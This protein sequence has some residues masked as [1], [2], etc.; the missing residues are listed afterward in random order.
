MK[1]SDTQQEYYHFTFEL[2]SIYSHKKD[3][4]S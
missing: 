4:R 3:S 1:L 2:P